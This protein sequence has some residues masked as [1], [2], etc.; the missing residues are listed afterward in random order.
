MELCDALLPRFIL[1]YPA[2]AGV[3]QKV[4]Q[5]NA[6]VMCRA[7][8]TVYESDPANAARICDIAIDTRAAAAGGV[9]T[10]RLCH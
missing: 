8:I 5:H 4:W 10:V 3:L 1:A 2:S 6:P 7:L 9:S